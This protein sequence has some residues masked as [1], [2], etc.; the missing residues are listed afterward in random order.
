M[1][2]LAVIEAACSAGEAQQERDRELNRLIETGRAPASWTK[3]GRREAAAAALAGQVLYLK[4]L[5][6]VPVAG[7]VGGA[8]NAPVLRR[9][10]RYAGLKYRRRF[11]RGL[12]REKPKG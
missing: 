6:G 10:L 3:K 9:V 11:L 5:Q 7:A 8:Y 4:F 1:F 2:V 12:R